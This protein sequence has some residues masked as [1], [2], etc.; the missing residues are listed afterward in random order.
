MAQGQGKMEGL[1]TLNQALMRGVPSCR[2]V[3]GGRAHFSASL[4]L[5]TLVENV[6]LLKPS[7]YPACNGGGFTPWMT[8]QGT[9]DASTRRGT[10]ASLL[11]QQLDGRLVLADSLRTAAQV[12]MADILSVDEALCDL[13]TFAFIASYLFSPGGRHSSAVA[14]LLRFITRLEELHTKVQGMIS[15]PHLATTLLFD[16]SWR[17][18]LYLNRCVA[19]L[20]SESLDSPGCQ[21]PFSLDPILADLEGG[22]IRR[23]NPPYGSWRP[24]IHGQR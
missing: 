22:L 20:A 8:W 4:P 9:V 17:W 3:F 6:S 16:V 7:L 5:L 13:G 15:S 11:S 24:C 1:A 2:R 10:D 18:I 12:R 21:V 14:E 19:A 23:A